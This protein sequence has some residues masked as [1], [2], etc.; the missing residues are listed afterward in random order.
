LTL[1]LNEG[2]DGNGGTD[3]TDGDAASLLL[4]P[5][6]TVEDDTL[7]KEDSLLLLV[8]V[9]GLLLLLLPSLEFRR[10]L[11]CGTPLIETNQKISG[12]VIIVGLR[13]REQKNN[14]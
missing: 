5:I 2:T 8:G 10:D 7:Q 3:G 12:I 13:F 1:T 4:F 11:L 9:L 6:S 14:G